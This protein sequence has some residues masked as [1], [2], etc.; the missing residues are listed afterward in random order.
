ML[1]MYTGLY[2]DGYMDPDSMNLTSGEARQKMAERGAAMLFVSTGEAR[3]L[4]TE[5][6]ENG[7]QFGLMPLPANEKG[8]DLLGI[9]EIGGVGMYAGSAYP[10]ACRSA[11]K[12]VLERAPKS[13]RQKI[14][15]WRT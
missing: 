5:G 9:G 15:T 4:V 6:A 7:D 1:T 12:G 3:G 10:Q 11:G 2:W 14:R 13:R 8:E